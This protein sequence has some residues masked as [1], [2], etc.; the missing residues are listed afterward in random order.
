MQLKLSLQPRATDCFLILFLWVY[1][2]W[3][4][5]SPDLSF[6]KQS[7]PHSRSIIYI[8]SSSHVEYIWL[9]TYSQLC[10]CQI[11]PTFTLRRCINRALVCFLGCIFRWRSDVML[12]AHRAVQHQSI[13]HI[14]SSLR[15]WTWRCATLCQTWHGLVGRKTC[16]F[17]LFFF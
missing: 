6:I 2:R 12:T 5:S 11:C 13:S 8:L 9:L 14:F 10:H 1:R 17:S 3:G 16:F 4:L 7:P 15:V